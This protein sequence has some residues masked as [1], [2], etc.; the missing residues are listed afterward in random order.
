MLFHVHTFQFYDYY[1]SCFCVL[2]VPNLLSR[3]QFTSSTSDSISLRVDVNEQANCEGVDGLTITAT[4]A[5]GTRTI[6]TQE[7]NFADGTITF[8]SISAGDYTCSVTVEDGTGPL[9]SMQT[10]CQIRSCPGELQLPE[11]WAQPVNWFDFK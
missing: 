6:S 11:L 9:E 4:I 10:P 8:E 2:L 1:L 3:V 5:E 7:A